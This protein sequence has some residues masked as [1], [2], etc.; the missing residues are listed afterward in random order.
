MVP[1]PPWVWRQC[2]GLTKSVPEHGNHAHVSGRCL[3][4]FLSVF[5]L[6]VVVVVVVVVVAVVVLPIF[7]PITHSLLLC[8]TYTVPGCYGSFLLLL[9][10]R[11]LWPVFSTYASECAP[12]GAR[13]E[14]LP[15]DRSPHHHPFAKRSR[16]RLLILL[17]GFRQSEAGTAGFTAHYTRHNRLP[18][19]HFHVCNRAACKCITWKWYRLSKHGA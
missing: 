7:L 4:G 9:L 19:L 17:Q 18:M 1:A 15:L 16:S 5:V 3:V 2:R 14:L 8:M 12:L 13:Q 10:F 6:L 11:W